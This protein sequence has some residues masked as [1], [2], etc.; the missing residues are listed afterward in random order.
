MSRFARVGAGLGGV[1]SPPEGV[2]AP[3]PGVGLAPVLGV[4]HVWKRG[5][6]HVTGLL[7]GRALFAGA[8]TGGQQLYLASAGL[9]LGWQ[10]D[11]VRVEAGP[12]YAAGRGRSTGIATSADALACA[13]GACGSERAR[14]STFGP[15]VEVGSSVPL[16]ARE[17]STGSLDIHCG[18]VTDGTRT[19]PWLTVALTLA[20]GARP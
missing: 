4:G 19:M 9:L 5:D 8:G 18:A 14:G 20:P 17:T 6:F 7:A 15:G 2:I 16:F 1:T 12:L 10:L 3:P 13:A 11:G